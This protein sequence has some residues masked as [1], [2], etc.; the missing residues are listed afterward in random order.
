MTPI[1]TSQSAFRTTLSSP[2]SSTCAIQARRPRSLIV[3]SLLRFPAAPSPGPAPVGR[4]A[5]RSRVLTPAQVEEAAC[6]VPQD[7]LRRSPREPAAPDQSDV[8]P[9]LLEHAPRDDAR[10]GHLQ[11]DLTADDPGEI[12]LPEERI[13]A[14]ELRGMHE[15]REVER[16]RLPIEWH[17]RRSIQRQ[18]V[19]LSGDRCAPK[20]QL[21]HRPVDL[22]QAGLFEDGGMRQAGKAVRVLILDLRDL[23]VDQ[24]A[25]VQGGVPPEVAGEH[26]HIDARLIHVPELAGDVVELVVEREL[27]DALLDQVPALSGRKALAGGELHGHEVMLEVDDHRSIT[28]STTAGRPPSFTARIAPPSAG[29]ICSGSST[30]P[31][32]YAP[33]ARAIAAKS[34]GGSSIRIPTTRFSTGRPRARAT[35]AW[36]FSSL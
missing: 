35:S 24:P 29:A 21:L 18:P 30:G 8:V 14:G 33:K 2:S 6:G 13:A 23:L 36:W 17:E 31:T 27:W 28:T 7:G 22:P 10:H 11:V 5:V 32:P 20:A 3:L 19:H 26:R 9:H 4:R 12:V 25:V 34:T 16:A 15:D 1:S